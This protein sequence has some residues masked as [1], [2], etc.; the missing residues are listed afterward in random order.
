MRKSFRYSEYRDGEVSVE[1]TP[2]VS[3][4]PPTNLDI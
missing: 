2:M 4:D 1:R 3:K